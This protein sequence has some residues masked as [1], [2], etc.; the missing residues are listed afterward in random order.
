VR[1]LEGASAIFGREAAR[2]RPQDRRVG[3]EPLQL[4]RLAMDEAD[5]AAVLS[6]LRERIADRLQERVAVID[7]DGFG[8][9]HD[10]GQFVI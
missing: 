9:V 7:G 8:E 3:E 2:R 10:L 5:A 4:D 6:V 1:E